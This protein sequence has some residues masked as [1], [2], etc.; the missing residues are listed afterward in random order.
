MILER[1]LHA[2]TR[3]G[4]SFAR[5]TGAEPHFCFITMIIIKY[6]DSDT[7]TA[8]YQMPGPFMEKYGPPV[9]KLKSFEDALTMRRRDAQKGMGVLSVLDKNHTKG[10]QRFFRRESHLV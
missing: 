6:R 1:L 9:V 7:D 10:I 4:G 2:R 3:P 5:L 8:N